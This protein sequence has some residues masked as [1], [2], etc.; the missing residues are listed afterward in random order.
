MATHADEALPA[1]PRR[2]RPGARAPSAGFEYSTNQVVL[3]TDARLLPRRPAARA[4]WNVEQADCRRPGE[5]LT[6]TY[7]MNR[8]QSIAGPV[9]YCVSVNPGDRRAAA[10]GHRRS[11]R[12]ATRTYTF[13]TLRRPGGAPRRCR[14]GAAPTTPAPTSGYGFHEDGCRSGLRGGGARASASRGAGRMRSHL[15]EGTVRHRRARPFVYALEHDV[16]YFA[17]DLSELDEVARRLRLVGRNRRGVLSFRDGDHLDPP[18]VDLRASIAGR[19]CAARVSIP[20]AGASRS[21]RTCGPSATCSTR[22]ASICAAIPRASCGSSIVE[23]HNTHRER[24]LYT[25]HR[26]RRGRPTFTGSMDKDFYVSPFIEMVGRYT[27]RVRDEA[28]RLRITINE[29]PGRCAR[30]PHE[31]R[32]AASAGDRPTLARM[33]IRHPFV[34]HKTIAHDPLARAAAVAPR[35]PLPSTRRGDP[36]TA[37]SVTAAAPPS[38]AWDPVLAR[39]AWRIGLAAASR[40]RIGGLTVVLPDGSRHVFGDR[41]AD[42]RAEIHIHDRRALVRMLLGGETGGGEAYMDGLWSSPDLAAL[43]R[44]AA[45]NRESLALSTGWFRV[46][47]QLRRTLAHRARRNTRRGSRRN[48]AAHYDLGN[49]FYRLVP[50]RDDDLLE[51][52][53]RDARPVAGRRP[54][55]QVPADRRGCRARRRG[56]H[57]LEIG[58]GWGGFA[59]YAAGELGCRVTSITISQGAVRPGAGARPRG[60]PGGPGRHPAA[61]LPRDQRHVRRDRVDRDARGGRARSTTPRSSSVCDAALAPGGRLSLQIDHLPGRRL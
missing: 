44:L 52:G 61:G 26:R 27:V 29:E 57:V 14:A 30:P 17:L 38:A 45:L 11:A 48:I 32:P 20:T 3:H 56:Q 7:H 9:Q 36:M 49:D 33:L 19:I 55:Q 28:T 42:A 21:S 51:R 15:L 43:L 60:R 24:H 13:R 16:Y 35:R 53:V 39:L 47:A 31:H 59:L 10:T 2:R 4:S 41:G 5:A 50:R 40:I 37:R 8:L 22:R 6:M 1:P 25:L 18:A 54:A 12:C 23:V 46:P 34:T 58:S